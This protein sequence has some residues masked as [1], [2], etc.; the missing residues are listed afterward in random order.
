MNVQ[1]TWNR[2]LVLTTQLHEAIRESSE[3]APA[4]WHERQRLLEPLFN[5]AH[6]DSLSTEELAWLQSQ[7]EA[8]QASE[9]QLLDA[10]NDQQREIMNSLRQQQSSAKAAQAYRQEQGDTGATTTYKK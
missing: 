6:L 8:L 3:R 1:H 9:Q 4:L 2:V 5:R 10:L 7:S